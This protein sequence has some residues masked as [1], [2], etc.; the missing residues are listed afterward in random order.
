MFT[1][2]HSNKLGWLLDQQLGT[3]AG[4]HCAV[5]ISADGLLHSRT[6]SID[7]DQGER[8]AAIASSLRGAGR[9]YGEAFDGGGLRQIVLELTEYV[10]LITQAGE[11]MLLLAQTTG[12]DAD[13]ATIAHQMG[14]LA[15]SVGDQM[16]VEARRP[17]PEAQAAG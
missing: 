5:L 10:C 14:E 8:H 9:S 6:S 16:A 17:V 2:T 13:I 15:V 4:V 7:Q 1:D 3:L 12:P 11:H